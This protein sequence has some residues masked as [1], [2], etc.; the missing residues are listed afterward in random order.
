MA[1]RCVICGIPLS[2]KQHSCCSKTCKNALYR[3]KYRNKSA[4]LE[5]RYETVEPHR[6]G[7]CGRLINLKTCFACDMSKRQQQKLELE[8]EAKSETYGLQ[9]QL[10]SEP[11]PA[12][13]TERKSAKIPSHLRHKDIID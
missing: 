3:Q 11:E 12:K 9:S 13:A 2:S 5:K 6:C 1:R 4:Y 7:G 10:G 8:R